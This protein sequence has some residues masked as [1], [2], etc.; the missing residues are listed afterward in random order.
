VRWG[1]GHQHPHS[2]EKF[3]QQDFT[4]QVMMVAEVSEDRVQ[5][6]HTNGIVSGDGDVM[7]L[8]L[9]GAEANVA[10]GLVGNLIPEPSKRLNEIR[11]G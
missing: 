11:R 3:S 10:S 7:R 6:S 2:F 1:A 8:T 5:G 9:E 4:I